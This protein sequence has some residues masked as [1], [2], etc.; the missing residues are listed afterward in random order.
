VT[1]PA[2]AEVW[3]VAVAIAATCHRVPPEWLTAPTRGRGAR[4]PVEAWEAKRHAIVAAIVVSGCSYTEIGRLLGMHKDTI[5]HHC[6][7]VARQDAGESASA[8]ISE[9]V[10]VAFSVKPLAVRT[11]ERR[12]F[13]RRKAREISF[14]NR[15]SSDTHGNVIDLFEEKVAA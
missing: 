4:P 2:V 9:T 7:V 15:H 8:K 1:R 5:S 12:R 14:I 6:A 11:A 10:G 3:P 13:E